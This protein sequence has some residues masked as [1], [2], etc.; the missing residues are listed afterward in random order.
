MNLRQYTRLKEEY[1]K[2]KR[3]E[4]EAEGALKQQMSELLDRHGVRSL[5]D[6]KKL[7]K[8]LREQ[9][10]E[11]DKEMSKLME[12]LEREYGKEVDNED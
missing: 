9:E 4:A 6:G 3:E 12:E 8:T 5:E 10:Q 2:H 1:E 11:L 7:L